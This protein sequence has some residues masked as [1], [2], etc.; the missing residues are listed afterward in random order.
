MS[1]ETR[2]V[3]TQ[4]QRLHKVIADYLAARRAGQAPDRQAILARHPE[5]AAE[6]AAFYAEQDQVHQTAPLLP[7][8]RPPGK[9][10]SDPNAPTLAADASAGSDAPSNLGRYFGDYELIQELARGGMGV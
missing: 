4:E 10:V 5:L 9:A 6:L 7:P 3:P 8:R 2:D 1:S